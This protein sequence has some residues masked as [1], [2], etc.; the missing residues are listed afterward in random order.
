MDEKKKRGF[1]LLDPVR[2]AE[3][4]S[5]GGKAAHAKGVAHRWTSEQARVAGAI[6]GRR[7]KKYGQPTTFDTGQIP[8]PPKDAQ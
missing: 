7:A 4:A 3:L 2:V 6:G 8:D 5:L 1:A